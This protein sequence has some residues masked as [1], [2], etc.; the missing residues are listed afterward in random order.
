MNRKGRWTLALLVLVCTLPVAASYLTYYVWP[1]QSQVNYGELMEPTPLPEGQVAPLGGFSYDPESLQG[2][3]VLVYVGP[4]GCD[5]GCAQALY[6]LRQVRLAL[7]KEMHRVD[8]LWLV[9]DGGEPAPGVLEGHAGLQV[10]RS[11]GTWLPTPSARQPAVG[12]IY[13]MDP[14][15]MVMMRYPLVPEPKRIIKDLERLLKYSRIG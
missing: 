1:P 13:L 11:D 7:G 12:H 8:R 6:Y 4:A 5:Q 2:H 10:A 14:L 3:W 9:S 15:G